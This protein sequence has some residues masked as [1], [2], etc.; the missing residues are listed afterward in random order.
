MHRFVATGAPTRASPQSA[1]RTVIGTT[2][3]NP[4]GRLLLEVAPETKISVACHQHFLV[5]RPVG[6]VT[7]RASLAH[8]LVFENKRSALSRVA[9]AAGVVL[10]EQ[11]GSPAADRR[12]FVG[13]VAIAATD[14]AAQHRMAVRQ[15]KLP[16]LVQVTFEAG[17]G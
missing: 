3:K 14:P 2:D 15:L 5:D 8:R 9:L 11:S 17:I 6:I 7:S 1:R 10:G 12:A 4:R 16:F 13:I